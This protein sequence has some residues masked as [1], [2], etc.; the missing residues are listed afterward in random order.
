[1]RTLLVVH[2]LVRPVRP[3]Q[4]ELVRFSLNSNHKQESVARCFA[5]Q[6]FLS[7]LSV[8]VLVHH[9][10][11][12]SGVKLQFTLASQATQAS[13]DSPSFNPLTW[14]PLELADGTTHTTRREDGGDGSSFSRS[15]LLP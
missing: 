5:A 12:T 14:L 15:V 8:S 7:V 4:L 11:Q 6:N 3:G 2:K 9:S 13:G 10:H 1:M